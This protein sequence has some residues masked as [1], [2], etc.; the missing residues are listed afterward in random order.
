MFLAEQWLT[1]LNFTI[2]S[3][4]RPEIRGSH[5]SLCHPE[6]YRITRALIESPSPAVKVICGFRDPD[7]IRLG[8]ASIYVTFSEIN[9][10]I[11]RIRTVVKDRLYEEFSTDR[12]AAT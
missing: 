3:P 6:A 9:K 4:A 2:G 5:V 1:P 12:L 7:N 10:A 8:V 11:D